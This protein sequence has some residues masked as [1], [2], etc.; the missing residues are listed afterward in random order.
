MDASEIKRI[1]K[2]YYE[3]LYTTK[4]DN[5]KGMDKFPETYNLQKLNQEEIVG[6]S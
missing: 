4:L 6:K 1:I 3:Q 2:D 5:V